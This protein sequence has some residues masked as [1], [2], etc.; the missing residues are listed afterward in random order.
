M[1]KDHQGKRFG[2]RLLEALNHIAKEVGCYKVS[3]L[4]FRLRQPEMPYLCLAGD[5][6]LLSQEHWLLREVRLRGCG[7]RDALLLR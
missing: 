7:T 1:I 6:G 2:L 4:F 5:L 3:S